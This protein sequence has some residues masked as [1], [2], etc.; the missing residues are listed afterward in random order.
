VCSNYQEITLLSRPGNVYSRVLERRLWPIV[1]PQLQEE[2]C[3]FHPGLV[4]KFAHPVYM[5]F[6]D[7][8]KAYDVSLGECCGS[9]G[10][11]G[12]WYKPF[13]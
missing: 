9:M 1:E 6:V 2:Q 12:R 11:R 13:G 7:L 3:E 10:Y 5:C 8:K 4:W